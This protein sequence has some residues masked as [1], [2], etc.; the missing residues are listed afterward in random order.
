[1]TGEN[2]KEFVARDSYLVSRGG[3][4]PRFRKDDVVGLWI[5]AFAGMTG[6]RAGMAG[7]KT[8]MAGAENENVGG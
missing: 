8:G 4:I 2:E 1:M 5:P 7:Q 3:L 6:E